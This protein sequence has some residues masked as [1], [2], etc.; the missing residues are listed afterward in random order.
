VPPHLAGRLAA[1][2]AVRQRKRQRR[3]HE[4]GKGRLD[5]IMQRAANPL[6]VTL[7]VRQKVPERAAALRRCHPAEFK[8]LGHD[9]KHHQPA[10]GIQ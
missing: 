8:H 9:Q 7:M 1:R 5:Q 2:A 6:D 10:V 4:K 3:P